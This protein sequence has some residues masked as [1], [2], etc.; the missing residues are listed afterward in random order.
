MVGIAS[1]HSFR[2]WWTSVANASPG[3][4]LTWCGRPIGDEGYDDELQT[5]Q[6]AGR[7]PDDYVEVLP[8]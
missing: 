3:L 5:D 7:R 6:C 8:S 1:F 4:R 2:T